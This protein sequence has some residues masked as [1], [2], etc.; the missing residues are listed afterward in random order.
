MKQNRTLILLI[1]VPNSGKTTFTNYVK[2]I[3]NN[4]VS[5][6]TDEIKKI[7]Y[8][9]NKHY[10]ITTLFNIQ[11]L[12][13]ES[14][15]KLNKNIIADSNSPKKKYRSNYYFLAQKYNYNLKIV[16]IDC[17]ENIVKPRLKSNSKDHIV[18]KLD[19]YYNEIDLPNS[20]YK[21]NNDSDLNSYYRQINKFLKCEKLI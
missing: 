10:D 16:Y 5:V 7:K 12:K 8:G 15:M 11:I 21:I 14:L 17:S 3:T 13:I 4:F 20:Y 2:K 9:N 19:F 6:S 1:G 18:N